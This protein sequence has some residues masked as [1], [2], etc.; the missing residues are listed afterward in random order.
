MLMSTWAGL[1]TCPWWHCRTVQARLRDIQ[2]CW[3]QTETT[4]G[5]ENCLSSWRNTKLVP[6]FCSGG[7]QAQ[8]LPN[9]PWSHRRQLGE[10]VLHGDVPVS[11]ISL[12]WTLEG[13]AG[14]CRRT[15]AGE[16][17]VWPKRH[18]PG[19]STTGER[20]S[21]SADTVK[22]T[23]T[24]NTKARHQPRLMQLMLLLLTLPSRRCKGVRSATWN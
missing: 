22:V 4:R 18:I 9:L 6:L 19:T 1:C 24:T 8:S 21:G 14:P 2:A 5:P 15:R 20:L 23:Q 10:V 11:R 12:L 3:L 7:P 17:S 16:W 13:L